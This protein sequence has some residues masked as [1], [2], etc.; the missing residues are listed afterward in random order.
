M[1]HFPKPRKSCGLGNGVLSDRVWRSGSKIGNGLAQHCHCLDDD[2]RPHRSTHD[3][4]TRIQRHE[5]DLRQRKD[6]DLAV[7]IPSGESRVE[8]EKEEKRQDDGHQLPNP[9]A[10]D[11]HVR[12]KDSMLK[13]DGADVKSVANGQL[14]CDLLCLFLDLDARSSVQTLLEFVAGVIQEASVAKMR[15]IQQICEKLMD[16]FLQNDQIEKALDV[17]VLLETYLRRVK[18][19]DNL[20]LAMCLRKRAAL[21]KT[22]VHAL[23][24]SEFC[25]L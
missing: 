7:A 20:S 2:G 14:A 17:V 16:T 4:T 3:G 6:R 22:N 18:T 19:S 21:E 13:Q 23:D 1:S 12:C 5:G 15:Q 11:R 24:A 10:Q 9:I 25:S 8:S